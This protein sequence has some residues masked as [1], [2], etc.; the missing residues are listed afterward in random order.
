MGDVVK[1]EQISI[2][3]MFCVCFQLYRKYERLD[4]R[5][6]KF[7]MKGGKI[8]DISYTNYVTLRDALNVSDYEVAKR[9]G[10]TRSTFSDW[11]SGR[12]KP[13]LDKLLKIADF[14][15]VPVTELIE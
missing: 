8:L 3:L 5:N 15:N 12:S 9:T 14:F 6:F 7:F 10:I 4:N 1:T 13:K 2:F 11:K